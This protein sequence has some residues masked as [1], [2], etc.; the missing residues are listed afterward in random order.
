MKKFVNW[1]KKYAT[2]ILLGII[3][4]LGGIIAIM[5]RGSRDEEDSTD[6]N[7][8]DLIN[9]D[10]ASHRSTE[11]RDRTR[12]VVRRIFNNRGVER[13]PDA[14]GDG[15]RTGSGGDQ[16]GVPGAAGESTAS[17]TGSKAE[18]TNVDGSRY[19]ISGDGSSLNS[20]IDPITVDDVGF[21]DYLEGP[22]IKRY[23]EKLLT[24]LAPL[25][26]HS[27][28]LTAKEIVEIYNQGRKDP[29]IMDRQCRLGKNGYLVTYH[30]RKILGL[31]HYLTDAGDNSDFLLQ[32]YNYGS[33]CGYIIKDKEGRVLYVSSPLRKTDTLFSVDCYR[34]E[35]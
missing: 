12:Q 34:W 4:I 29:S 19:R 6:H 31:S 21:L 33:R 1:I 10:I 35:E 15:N 20:N 32:G 14:D 17:G 2:I 23:G 7:D 27:R 3:S 25:Q 16:P 9:R 5:S 11:L 30:A 26:L 28:K 8:P 13:N 24:L 22:T 18:G